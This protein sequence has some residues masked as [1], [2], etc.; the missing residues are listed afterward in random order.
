VPRDP[1]FGRRFITAVAVG[2][3]LNPLNSTMVA[4]ALQPAA[5][6]L[7]VPL[8]ATLWLVLSLYLSSA[9]ALPLLGGAGDRWGPRRLY[10]L[11][12]LVVALASL[13]PTVWPTLGVAIAARALIGVGTSAAIPAAVGIIAAQAGRSGRAAS[14]AALA[15]VSLSAMVAI[16]VGPAL[17]G[18][19]VAFFG[20]RAIFWVNLPLAAAGAA[21]AIAWLPADDR[22]RHPA[23]GGAETAAPLPGRRGARLRTYARTALLFVGV[24]S[25]V[26]GV[27]PWTQD[28]YGI[29][30]ALSGLVQLPGAL[31]AIACGILMARTRRI[32]TPLLVA[33][34]AGVGGAGAVLLLQTGSPLWL[35][36]T[37]SAVLGVAQG[38]GFPANQNA[39]YTLSPAGRAGAVAG[40]GRV[41]MYAG[42]AASSLTVGLAYGTAPSTA[43]LHLI[44]VTMGVC[45]LG[46]LALAAL[47]RRLPRR[48]P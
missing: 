17:A 24:Y 46:S 40:L 30:V 42:A 41:S 5:T 38:F 34:A 8:E 2:P 48:L 33:A 22:R 4:V 14:P 43:G 3:A 16:A 1:F 35:L 9:A 21:C 6:Q 11:G 47:D 39:L 28:P 25:F 32:R 7:A 36:L 31:T 26:F 19:L 12:M 20:W 23:P 29:D 44:A 10:V 27:V 13:L 45:A 18:P 15:A 37:A